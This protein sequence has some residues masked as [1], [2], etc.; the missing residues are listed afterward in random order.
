[1]PILKSSG[2]FRRP[3]GGFTLIEIVVVMG[4]IAILSSMML[5]YS[6]RNSRQVLLATSQAK[7]ASMFARAK[8]LSIQSFFYSGPQDEIVCGH[9]VGIDVD[10]KRVFIFQDIIDGGLCS[11][12]IDDYE[13]DGGDRILEGELNQLQLADNGIDIATDSEYII[14]IPPEPLVKFSGSGRESSVV[15]SDENLSLG[16]TVTENGQ[17]RMD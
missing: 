7:L 5:G 16:I 1:M 17:I 12:D 10:A 13:F 14:F 11:R 8:F 15:I 3:R 4:I 2:F 6:Q 9:G